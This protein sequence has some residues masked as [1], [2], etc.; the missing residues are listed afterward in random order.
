LELLVMD[1]LGRGLTAI[2]TGLDAAVGNVA[3]NPSL[4]NTLGLVRDLAIETLPGDQRTNLDVNFGEGTVKTGASLRD[5]GLY[6]T[7]VHRNVQAQAGNLRETAVEK[8]LNHGVRKAGGVFGR[9]IPAMIG[10]LTTGTAASGGVMALPLG[11]WAAGDVLDTAA[12]AITGRGILDH[13]QNP[14]RVRGRSGAKRAME[15][16]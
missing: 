5:R 14:E 10:K 16:N 2:G 1:F 12:E 13:A 3:T 8:G 6:D 11:I 9:R 4:N 15:G 7:G